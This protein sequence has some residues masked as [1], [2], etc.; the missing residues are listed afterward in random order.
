MRQSVCEERH[1]YEGYRLRRIF[2]FGRQ[3]FALTILLYLITEELESKNLRFMIIHD[4]IIKAKIKTRFTAGNRYYFSLK[5]IIKST[6][7]Y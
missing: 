1:I 6:I 7:K 5:N 3:Y 4:N 2:Q